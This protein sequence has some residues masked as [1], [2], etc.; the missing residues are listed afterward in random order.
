MTLYTAIVR[1]LLQ[2]VRGPIP[3]LAALTFGLGVVAFHP[4]RLLAAEAPT[5]IAAPLI[6]NPKTIGAPQTAVLAGGCFWGVQGV[7]EH[8]RGVQKV[9]AGYS[10]GDRATA[11]YGIVALGKSGHAESVKITFDP[12]KV[13]YG[14]ILQI[15]F[16]VVLDPTQADGQGP[17]I[18]SEY[19]SVVFY[20]NDAQRRIALAY[21]RQL[22][23]SHVFSRPIV[24]G[25]H[26]LKG[27]Y[28]A[29]DYHQDFLVNNPDY[30]H[31]TMTDL[32]K[33]A[34]FRRLFPQYYSER[35]VKALN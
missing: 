33:I 30:P 32:P 7:F 23:N 4:S 18:G 20:S 2:K 9:L 3:V 10:G 5:T 21:I 35:P 8:L 19:R 1:L 17:D 16:S 26:P 12:A 31:I 22:T 14:E 6:D 15:A 28:Q 27:F 13:S 34:N 25:I 29:E 24:T 11:H